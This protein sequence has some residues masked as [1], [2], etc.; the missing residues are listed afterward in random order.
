MTSG[1]RVLVTCVT[2]G[3]VSATAPTDTQGNTYTKL[4]EKS[5]GAAIVVSIWTAQLSATGAN[6]VTM[7]GASCAMAIEV[8]EYSGLDTSAGT[9]C[10]DVSND[11]TGSTT[12]AVTAATPA[13]GGANELVYSGYG[14]NGDSTSVAPSAT[15]TLDDG[16]AP[17][18]FTT[19]VA[20]HKDS[21]GSGST[22]TGS[23]AAASTISWVAVVVVIKLAGGVGPTAPLTFGSKG[24]A[25]AGRRQ[26]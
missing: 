25:P 9:G 15:W 13:T 26:F 12:P 23:F 17:S 5:S 2:N 21:G 3:L 7:H 14:D 6:V 24:H 11:A 18:G 20:E 1:N 22:A 8:S 4:R 10:L 16:N 19:V